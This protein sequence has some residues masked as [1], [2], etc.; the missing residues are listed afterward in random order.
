MLEKEEFLS[1]FYS[2][3]GTKV[4]RVYYKVYG[5][6]NSY[7]AK[8]YKDEILVNSI[9]AHNEFDVEVELP[10]S[11]RVNQDVLNSIAHIPGVLQVERYEPK[12]S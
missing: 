9:V 5:G 10:N 3:D 12:I 1:E 7:I 8:C 2:D 6:G 11:Y 4:A